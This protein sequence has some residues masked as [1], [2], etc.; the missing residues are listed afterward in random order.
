MQDL[1]PVREVFK[2]DLKALQLALLWVP[3][4]APLPQLPLEYWAT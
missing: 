1:E 4:W 2:T 3:D